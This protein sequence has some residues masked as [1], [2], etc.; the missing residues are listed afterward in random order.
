MQR[1]LVHGK[2]LLDARLHNAFRLG[3]EKRKKSSLISGLAAK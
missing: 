3:E 2:M 1:K